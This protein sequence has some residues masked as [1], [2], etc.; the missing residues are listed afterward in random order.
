[1]AG[2]ENDQVFQMNILGPDS[3]S[4][5]KFVTGPTFSAYLMT[6]ADGKQR[7]KAYIDETSNDA[8]CMLLD[9]NGK[10]RVSAATM[11]DGQVIMPVMDLKGRQLPGQ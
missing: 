1:V 10:P 5:I 2:S 11:G 9:R 7:V 3:K 6:D 8:V 4:R